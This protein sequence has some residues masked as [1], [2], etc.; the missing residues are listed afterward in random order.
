MISKIIKAFKDPKLAVRVN[1]YYPKGVVQGGGDKWTN[2]KVVLWCIY[3][4]KSG[5]LPA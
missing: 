4:T 3:S 5:F 1:G 2:G